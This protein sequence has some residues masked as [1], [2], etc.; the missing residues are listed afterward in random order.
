MPVQSYMINEQIISAETNG[1][2][3]YIKNRR[4]FI[5]PRFID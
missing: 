2:K 5:W 1:I 3:F 4:A